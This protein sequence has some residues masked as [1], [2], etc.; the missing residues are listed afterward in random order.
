MKIIRVYSRPGCHLCEQLIEE[1]LPLVR[2][3]L[4]VEV[5]DIDSRPDWQAKFGV[6]IPVVEFDGNFVCQY[7]LDAPAVR[8]IVA[9]ITKP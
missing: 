3:H 9:T 5:V 1:L 2:G 4:D 6:R 7:T 8:E